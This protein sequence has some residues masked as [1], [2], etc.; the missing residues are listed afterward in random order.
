MSETQIV[1][2]AALRPTPSGTA[3]ARVVPAANARTRATAA[4]TVGVRA[5][6]AAAATPRA[7]PVSSAIVV[8]DG[9]VVILRGTLDF[10]HPQYSGW[11]AAL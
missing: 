2:T 1:A 6:L 11:L 9:Q 8:Y 4:T 10:S 5:T 3:T 7:V